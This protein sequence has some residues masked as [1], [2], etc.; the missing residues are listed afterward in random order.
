M[1]TA[2]ALSLVLRRQVRDTDRDDVGRILGATGVFHRREVDVAEELVID[3]L[4]KGTESEYLFIF[5]DVDGITAGYICYGAISM[6][7]AGFDLYWIATDPRYYNRGI[8]ATLLREAE[9]H[10]VALGGKYIFVETS[11]KVQYLPARGFYKKHGYIEVARVPNYYADGDDK[12]ILMTTLG[13][14]RSISL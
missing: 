3:A 5:A 6:T 2:E 9:G 14:E 11:S 12:V 10:I 13:G 7:E 4:E 1:Q 8:A